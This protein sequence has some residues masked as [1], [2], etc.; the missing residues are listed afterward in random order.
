MRKPFIDMAV[1]KV[2]HS[3]QVLWPRSRINIFGS[4]ATGLAL[5]TSDVDLVICLPPVRNLVI[6]FTPVAV[7]INS[8]RHDGQDLNFCHYIYPE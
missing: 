8:P 7:E 4:I 5:P 1:K 3:L 6:M 2:T